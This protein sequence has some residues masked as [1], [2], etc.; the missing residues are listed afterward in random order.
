MSAIA[1]QI[2]YVSVEKAIPMRRVWAMPNPCT[3]DIPPIRSLVKSYLHTAKVSVDPFAR[4]KRWATYTN[5]LSPETSAQWHMDAGDFLQYL[6]VNN[7]SPDLVL[8]DPPYSP[9]KIIECY[10]SIGL[11]VEHFA[12]G[13]TGRP[14]EEEFP[15]LPLYVPFSCSTPV[16]V[17]LHEAV[18]GL[19]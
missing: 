19:A 15:A 11:S 18:H 6:N 2:E 3:F 17:S 12:A 5:D 1:K 14:G 8:F 7:I 4:N 10:Q 9:A 16:V 13:K